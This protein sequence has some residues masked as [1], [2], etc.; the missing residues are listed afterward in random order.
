M[1]DS[2]LKV[3][4]LGTGT[5]QGVPMIAC[6]CK[7]CKSDDIKDNRLRSSIYIEKNNTSIVID[8]G[9]DFRQQMLNNNILELDAVIY[10]HE[11]K[12]HVAG[13]DD[14]RA[15]NHKYKKDMNIY[16]SDRVFTAL[17]REYIYIFN[18]RYFYP[19]IPKVNRHRI[20]SN[21]FY[22]DNIKIIPIE[23][24]H[25]K[26]P[27]MGFRIDDFCY[28]TDANFISDKEKLKMQEL[29]VLVINALRIQKHVSHFNLDESL[30][31]IRELNPK[32]AYLTHISHQLGSYADISKELPENV[33]LAYDGLDI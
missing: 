22:I 23:V 10:T 24:M 6:E 5:S 19:G 18:E 30:E 1:L 16:C 20:D 3:K 7:V 12:D 29:D 33:F 21:I 15:F 28:I 27:V 9:P 17:E 8:T 26:L 11:H 32:K 13:L 25:Y 4:F 31:L 2:N 14:I